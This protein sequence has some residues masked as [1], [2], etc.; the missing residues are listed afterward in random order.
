MY[1]KLKSHDGACHAFLYLEPLLRENIW[2]SLVMWATELDTGLS[3]S[4]CQPASMNKSTS[5]NRTRYS[6][7]MWATELHTSLSSSICQP[8][9]M[10]KSTSENRTRYVDTELDSLR[11]VNKGLP[12]FRGTS[13]MLSSSISVTTTSIEIVN[14][15]SFRSTNR[16]PPIALETARLNGPSSVYANRARWPRKLLVFRGGRIVVL[17]LVSPGLLL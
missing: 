6:L 13:S 12:L 15:N 7:V 8:A 17:G 11:T 1:T 16:S 9:S 10:N 3:S 2:I 4:I 5:G 14:P